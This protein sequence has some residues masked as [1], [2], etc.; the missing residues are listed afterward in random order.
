LEIYKE[1]TDTSLSSWI[2]PPNFEVGYSVVIKGKEKDFFEINFDEIENPV[3]SQCKN[4]TYYVKKGTLGTWVLNS[5]DSTRE[6]DP[7]PLYKESSIHSKIVAR[8]KPKKDVVV[9]IL[10]IDGEW[11]YV[12]T[13]SKGRK[14]YGWLNPKMQFGDPRGAYY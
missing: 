9:L 6:Y 11:M 8:L 10:D 7:V 3:N 5:N 1:P 2:I 13:M 12:K 4:C 14:K